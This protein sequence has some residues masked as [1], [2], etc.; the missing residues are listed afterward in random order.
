M[1]FCSLG[2]SFAMAQD[3]N[4]DAQEK[5]SYFKASGSYLTNS[6]YYGRTDSLATPYITPSVGYY[7]KSGF[8]VTGS[9]AYLASVAESRIDLY[10]FDIGYDFDFGDKFSGSISGNKSFY[11][12]SSTAIKSDIMGSL[13]TYV[14]Y[15]FNYLQLIGAADVS[16]ATKADIGVNV[17]LAHAFSF[18]EEN[19]K[20]RM[21][22]TVMANMST[23]HFYEGY[24]S[25]KLGKIARKLYPNLASSK[26]VTTVNNDKFTLLDYECSLPLTYDSKK[27][28]FFFIPTFAIPQNAITTTTTTTNAFKDGTQN[29][30]TK[31][32][33]PQSETNLKNTFFAEVGVYFKF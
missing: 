10:S 27:I 21:T 24:T 32:S 7:N 33:T 3:N 2:F 22:P 4:T 5:T 12:Q 9:L 6:V 23:L 26:S 16:F 11:N 8:Y 25:R 14:S 29:T 15:D 19:N 30:H 31:N 1:L 20:F 13:G 17:G 18:G 28:G